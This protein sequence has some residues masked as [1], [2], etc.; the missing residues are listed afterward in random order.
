MRGTGRVWRDFIGA[1]EIPVLLSTAK[2]QV[3]DTKNEM[4]RATE[5]ETK[6]ANVSKRCIAALDNLK[7]DARYATNTEWQRALRH[8]K[9][10]SNTDSKAA[11]L[12][13]IE[14]LTN[15]E[16][17]SID[18]TVSTG[19]LK[20]YLLRDAEKN[21]RATWERFLGRAHSSRN[22]LEGLRRQIERKLDG[23]KGIVR[24]TWNYVRRVPREK[25]ANTNALLQSALNDHRLRVL[26]NLNTARATRWTMSE[27]KELMKSKKWSPSWVARVS[28]VIVTILRSMG[29][30]MPLRKIRAVLGILWAIVK[31]S[32]KN[33]ASHTIAFKLMNM[34][35]TVITAV[36]IGNALDAAAFLSKLHRLV[37]A[38]EPKGTGYQAAV[39]S[40][41]IITRLLNFAYATGTIEMKMR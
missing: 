19:E 18:R 40:E 12:T 22:T 14:A 39:D 11:V 29:S 38:Q 31:L 37:Q 27:L 6:K 33:S 35:A 5:N 21:G 28:R 13:K 34:L 2:M 9:K 23:D 20:T 15:K 24:R 7:K 25:H 10:Y 36:E 1:K 26:P 41:R 17:G 16:L 4:L 3:I 30:R 32:R 8:V